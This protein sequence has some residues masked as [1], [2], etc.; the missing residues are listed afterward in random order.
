MPNIKQQYSLQTL[1]NTLLQ[2]EATDGKEMESRA[3]ANDWRP[4][5]V[6]FDPT[7][8][9]TS[10]RTSVHIETR[11]STVT[12]DLMTG[13]SRS[14]RRGSQQVAIETSSHDNLVHSSISDSHCGSHGNQQTLTDRPLTSEGCVSGEGV[15]EV[16]SGEEGEGCE[17]EVCDGEEGGNEDRVSDSH[18]SGLV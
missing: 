5:D 8:L 13:R 16:G 6:T 2:K 3:Q 7:T 17:G 15:E 14:E 18:Q 4:P 10:R 11:P 12:F 9:A 1:P